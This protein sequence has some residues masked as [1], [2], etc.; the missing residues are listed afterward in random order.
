MS[1]VTPEHKPPVPSAGPAP[2]EEAK[3]LERFETVTKKLGEAKKEVLG[4]QME[5]LHDTL[6]TE[7]VTEEERKVLTKEVALTLATPQLDPPSKTLLT[8]FMNQLRSAPRVIVGSS[9]EEE[10]VTTTVLGAPPPPSTGTPQV[11]LQQPMIPIHNAWLSTSAA[12][13][14]FINLQDIIMKLALSKYNQAKTQINVSNAQIDAA[15]QLFEM[16]VESGEL[17]AQL[18]EQEAAKA[19]LDASV[20]LGQL[21][22]S[23]L[24]TVYRSAE[25]GAETRKLQ[26][27]QL[28]EWHSKVPPEYKEI[29]NWEDVPVTIAMKQQVSTAVE[30]K[31]HQLSTFSE[32]LMG[33]IRGFGEADI[34]MVKANIERMKGTVEGT[35]A[36]VERITQF[37]ETQTRALQSSRDEVDQLLSKYM[38]LF[39]SVLQAVGEVFS[40]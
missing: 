19:S 28:K 27:D 30:N 26:E 34:A 22:M 24:Q 11:S 2:Q 39:R 35:K 23:S 9:G 18:A 4:A 14:L 32:S 12:V 13:Y 16:A 8:S 3:L 21:V 5:R 37:L 33:A 38:D 29:T 1:T 36:L 6:Q 25:T 15:K 7:G 40:A 20:A 31:V 17:A 10:E